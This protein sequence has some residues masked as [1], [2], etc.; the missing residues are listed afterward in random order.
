[1]KVKINRINIINL[2][3][4]IIFYLCRPSLKEFTQ[5]TNHNFQISIVETTAEITEALSFLV[6]LF[7]DFTSVSINT[8]FI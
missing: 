3:V 4:M 8:N 6:I 2:K 7:L 1:M 5:N